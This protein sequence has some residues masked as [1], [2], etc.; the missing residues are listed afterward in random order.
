MKR[1]TLFILVVGLYLFAPVVHAGFVDEDS[2]YQEMEEQEVKNF[3]LMDVADDFTIDAA[4][5]PSLRPCTGVVTSGFGFRRLSANSHRGRLHKGMDIA[6]PIG[7]P[8]LAPADGKVVFAGTKGGYGNTVIID[9]GDHVH[10]LF[11]HISFI[12]VS[13]GETVKKGQ[14]ISRVGITGHSTGPHLHYEVRIDGQPVNPEK[15][16]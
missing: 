8:I 1:I 14:E 12:E 13:E 3:Y 2:D 7:T 6:A 10:T 11:A 16:L 4:S 9:H 5:L 15:Y